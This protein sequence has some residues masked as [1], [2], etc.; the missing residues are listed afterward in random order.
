MIYELEYYQ[1]DLRYYKTIEANS[2]LEALVKAK[3]KG[4]YNAQ[5]IGTIVLEIELKKVGNSYRAMDPVEY[6]VI[7]LN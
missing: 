3:I 7:N 5:V 4:I 2:E 6:N 1:D